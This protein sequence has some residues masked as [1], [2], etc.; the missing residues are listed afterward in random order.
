MVETRHTVA[1]MSMNRRGFLG[2]S[3]AALALSA[4]AADYTYL[5]TSKAWGTAVAD[6][7]GDGH[8]DIFIT[9]HDTDDRIWYWTPSGYEPAAWHLPSV[10]RHDCS[11]ADVNLDGRMD[12]FCAVGAEGGAGVGYNELWL[13]QPDGTFLAV[14]NGAED[15]F[16]SSRVPVFLD[17]NHDG[18]PDLFI[19][20]E[21]RIRSDGHV[22]ENRLF[23]NRGDHFEEVRTIASGDT[24]WWCAVAGDIN[25]D[26]WD[27][28]LLCGTTT[29]PRVFL[30]DQHGG[31]VES[32]PVAARK[33]WAAARL[34]D[35]DHDGWLDLITLG[36]TMQVWMNGGAGFTLPAYEYPSDHG[37]AM[38]VGD[39]NR[40]GWPDIYVTTTPHGC[41][42]ENALIDT[43][44]VVLWGMPGAWQAQPLDQELAGCGHA[45]EALDGDKVLLVNGGSK[46]RGPSYVV[47][48]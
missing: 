46:V 21:Y 40:D 45:A 41:A 44:D 7:N 25:G 27:D 37:V 19:T 48:F 47:T 13:Q 31:F 6:Y 43:S 17:F 42:K 10:D 4:H 28:L 34:V 9:G 26:G 2:A 20:A 3:L 30:N 39:F 1:I 11:P 24:G 14:S 8:D 18:L 12:F 16:G 33:K 15:P 22:S 35:L 23:L 29:L 36:K 5:E 38:A 32:F